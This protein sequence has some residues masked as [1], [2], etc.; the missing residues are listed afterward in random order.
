MDPAPIE[1]PANSSAIWAKT[2]ELADEKLTENKL[3][4]LDLKNLASQSVN[5]EA[6]VKS[7][8][9][10]QQDEERKKWG[11]TWRGKKIVIAER[12]GEIIRS[13]GKY[14]GAIGT[15]VQC[16]PLVGTLVWAGIQG[17]MQVRIC[18]TTYSKLTYTDSMRRWL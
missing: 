6:V 17:I 5:I 14:S 16:D 7:L 13:M 9:D 15:A 11:Y 8:N 10:L 3:P 4:K 1:P 18:C 2:L 12:L